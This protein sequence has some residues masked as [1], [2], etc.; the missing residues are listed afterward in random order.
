MHDIFYS[1]QASKQG[2]KSLELQ[3]GPGERASCA[4]I[5]EHLVRNAQDSVNI[6][7]VGEISS[8][9]SPSVIFSIVGKSYS[10]GGGDDDDDKLSFRMHGPPGFVS[11]FYSNDK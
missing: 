11:L 7:F 4:C 8:N 5:C 1:K 2:K 9:E 10:G 3:G 6:V